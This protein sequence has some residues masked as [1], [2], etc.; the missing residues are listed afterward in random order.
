MY[1]P[2]I[3]DTHASEA[4]KQLFDLLERSLPDEFFC[5]HSKPLLTLSPSGL[6]EGEIDFV[7]LHAALG[8]LALEVKGGGLA[9][10]GK[11]RWYRVRA[12]GSREEL[13]KDPFAQARQN[14]HALVK[15][16]CS[17]L[18]PAFPEWNGKLLLPHGHAL[19]LPDVTVGDALSVP[20]G[21]ARE[22]L[23]DATTLDELEAGIRAAMGA[24]AGGRESLPARDFKRFRKHVFHPA[25]KLVPSMAA[26][27]LQE[28]AILRRL[29]DEQSRLL[30]QTRSVASARVEG[31][32]G[33]GKTV[34]AVE[35]ARRL[36]IAGQRVCLICF[37]R[38]LAM[39]IKAMLDD[40]EEHVH[41][42]TYHGLCRWA[43]EVLQRPFDVPQDPDAQQEFWRCQAPEFLME[44]ADQGSL[45][46]DAVVVDE[47]QDLLTE[48][49]VTVAALIP[50]SAPLWIFYDPDQDIYNRSGSMPSG[51]VPLDLTINCR[52]TQRLRELCDRITG[53]T[54]T[55]PVGAP[56]GVPHEEFQYTDGSD[57]RRKLEA[58]VSELAAQ[59][60]HPAQMVVLAPHR[61]QNSSL[62][63]VEAIA[64]YRIVTAQDEDRNGILFSTAR[65]F[66]GLEADVVLLVD[67]DSADPACTK[68]HRYVAS[69]RARHLLVV[70]ARGR[71]RWTVR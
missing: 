26:R 69:S 27:V 29:T 45:T 24:W 63:G 67:Q 60:L 48:W 14:M 23:L 37:N 41:V 1:P 6:R 25:L 12:D 54:T 47:A 56:E 10:D 55:S 19:I 66:K 58:R 15:L 7:I 28:G 4:E 64:G 62:A 34:L 21:M 31:P 71:G 5:Y 46:F 32:A 49:W 11:G 8:L 42:S 35:K 44:A 52:A 36:A 65:R 40:D 33:T 68:V 17:R 53:R 61:Q 51:L 16:L 30:D 2:R 3:E 20:T 50:A 9:R 38:P 70:F 18:K 22:I 39:A 57:L 13:H 43:A 59:G